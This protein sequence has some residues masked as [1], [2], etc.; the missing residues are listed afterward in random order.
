MNDYI[1]KA[2]KF[3]HR[4]ATGHSVLGKSFT[5]ESANPL[6]TPNDPASSKTV[7]QQFRQQTPVPTALV[8]D[9]ALV[10]AAPPTPD[11]SAPAFC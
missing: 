6:Y 5:V 9:D 8:V 11:G 4:V 2:V 10:L 7:K 1:G 3:Q